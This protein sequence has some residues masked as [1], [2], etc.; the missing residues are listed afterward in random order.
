MLR[1]RVVQ[2]TNIV[3][4]ISR[5]G[6][7][8][9]VVKHMRV[10]YVTLEGQLRAL[11]LQNQ[12]DCVTQLSVVAQ[13]EVKHI[14]HLLH[15]VEQVEVFAVL[16]TNFHWVLLDFRPVHVELPV[17]ALV[18]PVHHGLHTEAEAAVQSHAEL[19]I[20]SQGRHGVPV[21]SLLEESDCVVALVVEVVSEVLIVGQRLKDRIPIVHLGR[22]FK[23]LV[24][25]NGQ[26][27]ELL[28][29]RI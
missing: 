3:E 23:V 27:A 19:V 25:A 22:V 14:S 15:R 10:G 24:P 16:A 7:L 9:Q 2:R 5:S 1:H 6:L 26:L 20:F 29:Y 17:A 11:L 13:I 21:I 8:S 18:P 4:N 12:A 28:T